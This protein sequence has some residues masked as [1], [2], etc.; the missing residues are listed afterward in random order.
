M[1]AADARLQTPGAPDDPPSVPEGGSAGLPG[2]GA[3]M[4]PAARSDVLNRLR[5]AE[6]QLRGIQRMVERGEDCRKVAQ[7][8][9]AVRR[10][11]D[12]TYVRMTMCLLEQEVAARWPADA[13]M[14]DDLPQLL[15]ELETL[16]ARR[17]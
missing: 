6:G 1:M 12:S 9:S 3:L 16:L 14:A 7:Q 5:R 15:G 13:A 4:A 8:F 11:L 17:S 10:A 2:T